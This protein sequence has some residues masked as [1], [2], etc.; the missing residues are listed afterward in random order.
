MWMDLNEY[1]KYNKMWFFGLKKA[2]DMYQE[3]VTE[4]EIRQAFN[5]IEEKPTG[6]QEG[7]NDYFEYVKKTLGPEN[8]G[9]QRYEA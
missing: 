7:V 3:G 8:V 5:S 2:E 1:N 4:R 6:L 9:G